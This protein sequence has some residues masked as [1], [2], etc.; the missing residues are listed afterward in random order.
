MSERP[1]WDQYFMLI[2]RQVAD[3]STCNRAKV[4]AVFVRDKN[5]LGKAGR[6]LGRY[7]YSGSLAVGRAEPI[8]NDHVIHTTIGDRGAGDAIRA[9]GGPGDRKRGL[10]PLIGECGST[11]GVHNQSQGIT[12]IKRAGRS[13]RVGEDSRRIGADGC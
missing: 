6:C 10:A 1:S 11:T 12:C 9:G 8:G 4:G 3:R 7:C 13:L 5:I 2:T